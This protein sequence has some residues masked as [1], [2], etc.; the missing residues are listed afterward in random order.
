MGM[1][2]LKH[3]TNNIKNITNSNKYKQVLNDFLVDTA[4]YFLE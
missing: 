4:L 3:L 1:K 2:F